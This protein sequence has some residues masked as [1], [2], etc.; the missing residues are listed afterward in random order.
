[1]GSRSWSAVSEKYPSGDNV[2]FGVYAYSNGNSSESM[3]IQ[4]SNFTITYT[5]D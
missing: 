5:P 4:I 1:M 2:C 3:D